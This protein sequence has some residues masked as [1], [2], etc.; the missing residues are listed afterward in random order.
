MNRI[1]PLLSGN[2]NNETDFSTIG[3]D[4]SARSIKTSRVRKVLELLENNKVI[5]INLPELIKIAKKRSPSIKF[6]SFDLNK[7]F[8]LPDSS[9]DQVFATEIVEH[10]VDDRKFLKECFRILKEEGNIILSTLQ[11]CFHKRS[12]MAFIWSLLR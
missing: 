3:I 8:P 7:K 2:R 12:N 6:D 11:H 1:I 4:I 10:I 5:E 9:S